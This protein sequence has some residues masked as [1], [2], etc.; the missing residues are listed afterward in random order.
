MVPIYL[1]HNS[2]FLDEEVREGHQVTEDMKKLW[3][4]EL[5]LLNKVIQVC[6]KYGI[7]YFADAGTLLGAVRHKG[8]IPWDDDIDIIMPRK[9]YDRFLEVAKEE[10][11]YPYYADI[12]F[13]SGF[14]IKLK[15]LDTSYISHNLDPKIHV[16]N[17]P[18]VSIDIF[19]MD[20]C[21]GTYDEMIEFYDR[22]EEK[23]KEYK[24]AENLF[25]LYYH[26][27]RITEDYFNEVR[28]KYND[29]IRE[30]D[31]LCQEYNDR[32]TGYLFNN[33]FPEYHLIGNN[34]RYKE[35]YEGYVYLPFEM[36]TLK[37]PKGY[38]RCLDVMYTKRTGVSWKT[39]L[40][41]SGFHH[42]SNK[43]KIDFDHPY[44]D[45]VKLY[46]DRPEDRIEEIVE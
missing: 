41:D 8:F 37:C 20:S 7:T 40:K 42:Q 28:K 26:Y 1:E 25:I 13:I 9:D 3:L 46:Y 5:D 18:C 16:Y 36:L 12:Y 32:N 23:K 17:P 6:D 39:P 22:L 45:Y 29:S 44:T 2:R 35:D 43:L 27:D 38:E 14:F 4:V 31:E 24:K 11:R 33:C 10:I 30:F 19:C 21:P 15:R 34:P